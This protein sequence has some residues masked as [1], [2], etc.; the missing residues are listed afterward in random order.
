M[1][2]T[3]SL[4]IQYSF[5]V[6]ARNSE[7]TLE[8]CFRSLRDAAVKC[9]MHAVEIIYVD[10]QSNDRSLDIAIKQADRVFSVGGNFCSA[11]AGRH[12]GMLESKGRY[13]IFVDGDMEI[14]SSWLR[15]ALVAVR[16]H[17][18]VTG[19]RI[20]VI[21]DHDWNELGRVEMYR[22]GSDR[23]IGYYARPGGPGGLLVVDKERIARANYSPMLPDEEE[24]DFYAQFY[25]SCKIYQVDEVAF[26]HHTINKSFISKVRAY[27]HPG[28]NIGHWV[29]LGLAARNGY[30]NSYLKVQWKYIV[31]LASTASFWSLMA[32]GWVVPAL[33]VILLSYAIV[34]RNLLVFTSIVIAPYKIICALI[35]GLKYRLYKPRVIQ[36]PCER[37]AG[38]SCVG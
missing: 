25:S 31:A 14:S 35:H 16:V 20:D 4:K 26:L 37:G 18:A 30:L 2:D 22:A 19:G 21:Y 17:G 29:S 6:I 3:E 11:A 24:S 8:M 34:N 33:M 23:I 10:S 7:K 12:I 5:V 32:V 9:E 27:L 13:R 28:R 1:T 15:K 38:Q 36:V